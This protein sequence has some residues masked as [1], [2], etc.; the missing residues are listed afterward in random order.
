MNHRI[1]ASLV[2]GAAMVSASALT[3]ALTPT[4]KLAEAQGQFRLDAM[5]PMSFGEWEV[6]ASIVPL[7]D[8]PEQQELLD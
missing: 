2:L 8:D 5:I 3:G 6:D 1:A 7:Q 4:V